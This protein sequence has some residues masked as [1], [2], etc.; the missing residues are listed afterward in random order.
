MNT[1]PNR[2]ERRAAMKH[3]GYLKQKRHL[4][5]KQWCA[6]NR[7]TKKRGHEIHQENLE[8]WDKEKTEHLEGREEAAIGFWK[9]EGYDKKEI[10]M[11]REAWAIYA[12]DRASALPP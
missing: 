3:A 11:L 5:Y 7:E 2:K 4:P 10:E 12:R 9:E 6:V 8:V 1:H